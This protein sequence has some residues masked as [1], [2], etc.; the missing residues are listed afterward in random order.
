MNRFIYE[1][2]IAEEQGKVGY[3]KTTWL[4]Y[5][6]TTPLLVLLADSASLPILAFASEENDKRIENRVKITL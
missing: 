6:E 4:S 2:L 1:L 5:S 3:L